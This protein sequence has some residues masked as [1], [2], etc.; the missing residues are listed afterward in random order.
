[1]KIRSLDAELFHADGRKDGADGQA[2]VTKLIVVFRN[3]ANASNQSLIRAPDRCFHS[4]Y[5]ALDRQ[6]DAPSQ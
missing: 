3:F 6:R 2:D 4:R 1:M 5:W